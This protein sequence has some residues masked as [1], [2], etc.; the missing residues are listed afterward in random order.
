MRELS[1][2]TSDEWL[3]LTIYIDTKVFGKT[4]FPHPQGLVN[5]NEEVV[6]S[7]RHIKDGISYKL[8]PSRLAPVLTVEF[9]PYF[10]VKWLKE[11]GFKIEEV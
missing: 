11:K 7:L 3:S 2:I 5:Y 4:K 6:A 9:L 8:R 1:K 10:V